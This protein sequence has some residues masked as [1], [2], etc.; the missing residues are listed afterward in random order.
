MKVEVDES[1]CLAVGNCALIAPEVFDQGDDDGTVVVL[2]AAPP[3]H[4]HETVRAAALRC[5]ASVITL[6]D[7]TT[8]PH[9]A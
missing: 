4:T 9:G 2:D 3:E 1:R 5:P 6:H 8:P 7:D